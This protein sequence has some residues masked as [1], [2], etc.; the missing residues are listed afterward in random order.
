MTRQE[1]IGESKGFTASRGTESGNP[2]FHVAGRMWAVGGL[3][4]RNDVHRAGVLQRKKQ[5][6]P[7]SVGGCGPVGCSSTEQNTW[8]SKPVRDEPAGSAGLEGTW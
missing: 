4:G 6:L 1:V 8:H 3:A 5:S 2:S 7:F